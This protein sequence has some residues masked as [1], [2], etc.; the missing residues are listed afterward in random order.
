MSASH[1]VRETSCMVPRFQRDVAVEEP[2]VLNAAG[3]LTAGGTLRGSGAVC[4]CWTGVAPR[5]VVAPV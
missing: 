2:V 4:G 1:I 3:V 5:S